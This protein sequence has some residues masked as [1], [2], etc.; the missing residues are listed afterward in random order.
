MSARHEILAP[1]ASV[2]TD[3]DHELHSHARSEHRNRI[4]ALCF[5][6]TPLGINECEN[7]TS[8]V[9]L[10]ST[11]AREISLPTERM[12]ARPAGILRARP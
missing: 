5:W 3:A 11:P 12:P 10:F 7:G 8:L 1:S 2:L 9:S 6:A 4:L